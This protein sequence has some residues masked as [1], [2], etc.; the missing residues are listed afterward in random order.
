VIQFLSAI[1]ASMF[2]LITLKLLLLIG[3]AR[4]WRAISSDPNI[5]F[6]LTFTMIFAFA[7]GISTYNFGSLSRYRI[8]CLPLY[9]IALV[10]INYKF[11]PADSSLFSFK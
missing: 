1:E 11:R 9:A 7:V 4:V 8:P 3:P 2:L 10:L 6:C 5:Q